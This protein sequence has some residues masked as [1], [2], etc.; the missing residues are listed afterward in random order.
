MA[1][2]LTA[3]P[4]GA[5]AT[6]GLEA[7]SYPTL[8]QAG[9]TTVHTFTDAGSTNT[10]KTSLLGEGVLEGPSAT[11]VMSPYWAECTASVSPG[12]CKFEFHAG[13]ENSFD[14]GPPGCGPIKTQVGKCTMSIGS[15][16]GLP[17][18]YV[19]AGVGKSA[20]I[21]VDVKAAGFTFTREGT[22]CT[23]GT[24]NGQYSGEWKLKGTVPAGAEN[25]IRATDGF[26]VGF[27]L[28]GA[29]SEKEAEQPRFE[30]EKYPTSLQGEQIPGTNFKL[31]GIVCQ[32]TQLSAEATKSTAG[33]VVEANY[34]KCEAPGVGAAATLQMN[35]CHY[36]FNLA[37]SGPPYTGTSQLACEKEG[38]GIEILFTMWGTPVKMKIPPQTL[39]DVVSYEN[40]G[41]GAKRVVSASVK[42]EGITY[43]IEIGASKGSVT[44]GTLSESLAMQGIF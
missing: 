36:V 2:V 15:Q 31:D 37:N 29:K 20:Y 28:A 11:V 38:D 9:N 41:T 27:F 25:G 1:L 17:A 8:L 30:A 12:S 42:G 3:F 19:N 14:I 35:S 13:S 44:N 16:S 18:S 7:D 10:C 34:T 21:L 5:S 33:L 26:P 23:K 22:G 39:G 43:S 40:Q 24:F 6:G 32:D 4:A